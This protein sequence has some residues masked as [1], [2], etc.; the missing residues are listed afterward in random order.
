MYNLLIRNARIARPDGTSLEGDVACEDGC[1]ARIDVH[2]RDPGSEY[3]EDLG[4]EGWDADLT[5]VDIDRARPVRNEETFTKVGWSP[6]HDGKLYGWP[7]YT[8]V[9]GVSAFD[10]GKIC[11]QTRSRPLTYLA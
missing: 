8:I 6:W 7:Q 9:N 4:A 5:L 3:K 11:E 1:I 2:F 10:H